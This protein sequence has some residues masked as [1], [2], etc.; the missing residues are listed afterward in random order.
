MSMKTPFDGQSYDEWLQRGDVDA[1]AAMCRF[2]MEDD[3]VHHTLRKIAG[4]LEELGIA[5]AIA[6]GMALGAHRFVR[7]TVDVDILVSA[8]GLRKIHESLD[9][10]GFIPPFAG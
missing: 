1:V 10:R 2:F 4:K 3:P 8:D 5:Y 6:G 9:G 7:A